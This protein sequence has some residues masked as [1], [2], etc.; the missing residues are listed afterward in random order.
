MNSIDPLRALIEQSPII[1]SIAAVILLLCCA[2]LVALW[3]LRLRLAGMQTQLDD[4]SSAFRDLKR[5]HE[6]LF[7]RSLNLPKSRKARKSSSPSSGTLEE[8]KTTPAQPDDKNSQGSAL[9]LVSPKTS[10][11]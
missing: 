11:E 9:Y 1:A 8:N 10:P 4:L 5:D 3:R 2:S 6:R 7:I